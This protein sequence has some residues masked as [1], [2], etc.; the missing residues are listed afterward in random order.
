MS[1]RSERITHLICERMR[2]YG[3]KYD[4]RMYPQLYTKYLHVLGVIK[5]RLGIENINSTG[6]FAS[7]KALYEAVNAELDCI[8]PPKKEETNS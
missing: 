7:D 5:L 4:G 6:N 3:V 1:F 8:L 2:E